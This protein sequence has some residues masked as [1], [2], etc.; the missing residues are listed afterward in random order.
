M[1]NTE[2]LSCQCTSCVSLCAYGTPGWFLPE[3]ISDVAQHLG[4]SVR[5]LKQKFLIKDHCS[6]GFGDAPYVYTPRK[7]HE[8]DRFVIKTAD[9]QATKGKCIFLNDHNKC[10]IHEVKPYEC[11]AAFGCEKHDIKINSFGI[12]DKIEQ[13]YRD[14]EYPLGRRPE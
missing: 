10:S 13:A 14:A 1:T 2:D 7:I 12:R 11:Q 9:Q 3:Q 6:P 5:E 8:P 4:I